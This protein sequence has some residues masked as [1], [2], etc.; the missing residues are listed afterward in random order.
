MI[1]YSATREAARA[2]MNAVDRDE[3]GMVFGERTVIPLS[4]VKKM[5]KLN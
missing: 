3:E 5:R 2:L 4:C 1:D